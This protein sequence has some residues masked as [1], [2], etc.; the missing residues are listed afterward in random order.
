M[1]ERV[2]VLLQAHFFLMKLRKL[3][4]LQNVPDILGT[5]NLSTGIGHENISFLTACTYLARMRASHGV[6]E[7]RIGATR[8]VESFCAHRGAD[9]REK[10]EVDGV[11]DSE[12]SDCSGHGGAVDEAEMLL[13]S[14]RDRLD[15]VIAQGFERRHLS[16]G[17]GGPWAVVD[18]DRRVAHCE[19]CQRRVRD[20]ESKDTNPVCLQC[21]RE[22]KDLNGSMLLTIGDGCQ[23]PS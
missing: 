15:A 7:G 11:V 18:L 1:T 16:A 14:E 13:G 6:D 22:G 2:A 4:T 3:A 10:G 8:A 23:D 21:R 9:L 12:G 5:F 17:T 19:P 20:N